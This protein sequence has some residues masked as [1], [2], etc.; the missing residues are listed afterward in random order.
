MTSHSG[1][2][3]AKLSIGTQIAFT[4]WNYIGVNASVTVGSNTLIGERTSIRDSDHGMAL[5]SLFR[6]QD[7][8]AAPIAIGGDVWIGCGVAIL[9]GS[10]IG[11]SAVVGANTVV[12]GRIEPFAIVAGVP[13]KVIG[14]RHATP[15]AAM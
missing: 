5:G 1:H 11:D 9:K 3:R 12:R 8:V 14:S 10:T 7:M 2:R 4:A 13:A 6:T 15:T